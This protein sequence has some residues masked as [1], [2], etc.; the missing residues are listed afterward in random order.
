M[1]TFTTADNIAPAV[2]GVSPANG[3][4]QVLLDASIRVAFSEPVAA[5]TLTLRNAAGAAITGQAA[6]TAGNTALAFAPLAFLQANTT[7]TATLTGVTDTAGNALA[8]PLSVTFST[9][10][11]IGPTITALQIGGTARAGAQIS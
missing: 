4:V 1:S 11:T 8:T 9:L 7:Y 3:A 6:F 2:V 10:D 5:G